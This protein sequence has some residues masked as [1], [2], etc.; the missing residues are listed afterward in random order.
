M[1]FLSWTAFF[2]TQDLADAN[3]E[4]YACCGYR[5]DLFKG[6][7]AGMGRGILFKELPTK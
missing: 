4:G 2:G 7:S 6:F 3:N 5:S 1:P